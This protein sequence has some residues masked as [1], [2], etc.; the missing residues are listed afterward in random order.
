MINKVMLTSACL[1]LVASI[2]FSGCK[3][4]CGTCKSYGYNY[5]LQTYT[6]QVCVNNFCTCPN[7]FEGDSCQTYS[8]NKYI[9]P[10]PNWNAYDA[11]GNNPTYSVYI[12]T[13]YP[14]YNSFFINNLFNSGTQ[15]LAQIASAANNQ[16]TYLSIPYQTAGALSFSGQ[17]FYQQSGSLGKLTLNLDFIGGNGIEEN[18][19]VTMYQQ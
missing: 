16:G 15:V 17:G 13:N 5:T 8:L 19:T 18:C 1:L 2:M 10:S 6:S 3:K 4:G 7:G 11:C 12:T 14:S 9:Q